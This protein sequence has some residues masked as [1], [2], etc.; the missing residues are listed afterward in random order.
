MTHGHI[1]DDFLNEYRNLMTYENLRNDIER[2]QVRFEGVDVIAFRHLGKTLIF[3]ISNR[4]DYI[5]KHHWRGT[6]YELEELDI[7]KRHFPINGTFVD[8]GANVGNHAVFVGAYLNP[9]KIFIFEPNPAAFKT[10]VAN[11]VLNNLS[12]IVDFRGLGYGLS[13]I[14]SEKAAM[15]IPENNIGAGR[16]VSH[17][18]NIKILPGDVALEGQVV[19]FLKIDV[20][21]LELEVLNGLTRVISK[22]RPSMFIEVNNRNIE[23]FLDKIASMNYSVVEEFKRHKSNKNFMVVPNR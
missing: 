2:G 16:I 5:Q 13:D 20:E 14:V 21:G 8:I 11:M 18:G 3:S 7:I 4:N 9:K 15:D 10:L 22:N 12:D 19:D 1:G 17:G 6:L 23:N